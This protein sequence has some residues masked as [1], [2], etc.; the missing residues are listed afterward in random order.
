[1]LPVKGGEGDLF[2]DLSWTNRPD[3]SGSEAPRRLQDAWVAT[4]LAIRDLCGSV[5]NGSCHLINLA[6][7]PLVAE[8]LGEPVEAC[9]GYGRFVGAGLRLEFGLRW[10]PS[11][12]AE[13]ID[14]SAAAH[15]LAAFSHTR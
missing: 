6:A 12:W 15:F 8:A 1:M 7:A 14:A 2:A 11:K 13:W 4:V 3:M 5:R 9:A 10:R